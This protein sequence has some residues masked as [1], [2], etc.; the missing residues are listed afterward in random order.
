MTHARGV[1]F[2]RGGDGTRPA[3]GAPAGGRGEGGWPRTRPRLELGH[4]AVKDPM[5]RARELFANVRSTAVSGAL[6]PQSDAGPLSRPLER[7]SAPGEYEE[8]RARPALQTRQLRRPRA[9]LRLGPCAR[10][11]SSRALGCGVLEPRRPRRPAGRP[12]RTP[13]PSSTPPRRASSPSSTTTAPTARRRRRSSRRRMGDES[14]APKHVIDVSLRKEPTPHGTGFAILDPQTHQLEIVTAAH[15]VLRPD[16]LQAHDPRRADGRRRA[17]AHRRGARRRDPAAEGAA[18]GRAAARARRR[19][20]RGRRA[21]LGARP[22]RPGLLGALVGDE[23]GDRLGHRRDVRREAAAL[24]RRRLPGL[25]RRAGG[26][27]RTRRQ[28]AH[29]RRQPRHP[30]HRAARSSRRSAPSRA[31]SR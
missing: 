7:S 28:A 24:R 16:R 11:V 10:R 20:S 3:F 30:L 6:Q 19:R 27:A 26:R 15:V 22:H 21:G 25:L 9:A 14:H 2:P 1:P 8:G 12:S 17:R 31:P 13:T 23:R 4:G 29:R 18:Q 5:P